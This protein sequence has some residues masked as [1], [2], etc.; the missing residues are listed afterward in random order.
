MMKYKLIAAGILSIGAL[1]LTAPAKAGMMGPSAR[2]YNGRY[3]CRLDDG[4]GTIST[5]NDVGGITGTYVVQPNGMGA[6]NG[7][8]LIGNASLLWGDN[9]CTFTLETSGM[10]PSSYWV[11]WAGVVYETLYWTDSSMD[12]CEGDYFEVTNESS[13]SLPN[14]YAAANQLKITSNIFT[15]VDSTPFSVTGTGDCASSAN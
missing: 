9:P 11:D 3:A 1:A 15:E 6:Y 5:T 12:A 7:G 4:T 2:N 10:Y 13:M 14:P 8:E